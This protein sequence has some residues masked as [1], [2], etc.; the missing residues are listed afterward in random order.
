M[1]EAPRVRVWPRRR[2]AVAFALPVLLLMP[3][4]VHSSDGAV[5]PLVSILNDEL[6]RE[7]SVLRSKSEP[8]PYYMAYEVIE[9]QNDTAS[10]TMGALLQHSK[11]HWRTVDTTVRVGTPAS[12]ITTLQL[13]TLVSLS[14]HPSTCSAWT[15]T[16]T[17]SPSPRPPESHCAHRAAAQSLFT[18]GHLTDQQL[19]AEDKEKNAACLHGAREIGGLRSRELRREQREWRITSRP[20]RFI[21]YGRSLGSNANFSDGAKSGHAWSATEASAL[22]GGQQTASSSR[23]PR[24][25]RV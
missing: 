18:G 8:A 15:I 3:F 20:A 11:S 4:P 5:A 6:N 14:R 13:G 23:Y 19:I 10:A 9:E 24:R 17:D 2:K 21:L 7:F 25:H 22:Q 16:P 1:E 12:T